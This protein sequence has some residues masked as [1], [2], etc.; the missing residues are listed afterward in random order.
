MGELWDWITSDFGTG[1]M[2]ALVGGGFTLLGTW[3]QSRKDDAAARLA[4]TRDVAQ[5]AVEAV[6]TVAITIQRQTYRGHGTFEDREG[7]GRE[8][9]A[10]QSN[11]TALLALLPDDQREARQRVFDLLEGVQH[12][13]GREV[14]EHYRI[15]TTLL[16]GEMAVWLAALA[17]SSELP[18]Y[19]DIGMVAD[20]R[21][22]DYR[23]AELEDQRETLVVRAEEYELDPEEHERFAE[24]DAELEE[25]KQ[26]RS[27]LS[28][29]NQAQLTSS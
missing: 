25:I 13:D 6:T 10:H 22:L 11:L 8:L 3:Y 26:S 14:W 21:I 4:H 7:W 20:G 28:Q 18:E 27:A 24:I 29:P 23:Q 17:R 1:L 19:K 15:R 12:W 5:R 9:M 2:G 16:L